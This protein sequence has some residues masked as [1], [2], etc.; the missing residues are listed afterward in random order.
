MVFYTDLLQIIEKSA[1]NYVFNIPARI[2]FCVTTVRWR[3]EPT[4]ATVA[5][6]SNKRYVDVC[7]R[8]SVSMVSGGQFYDVITKLKTTRCYKKFHREDTLYFTCAIVDGSCL[9]CVAA[10]SIQFKP[11][12]I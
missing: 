5:I 1:F 2:I 11:V 6:L 10:S 8:S 7:T 9:G 12:N 4:L 3:H